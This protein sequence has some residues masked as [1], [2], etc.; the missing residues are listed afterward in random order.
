MENNLLIPFYKIARKNPDIVASADAYGESTY[1]QL[2]ENALRF[3]HSISS[4]YLEFKKVAIFLPNGTEALSAII[5]TLTAGIC[6]TALD[7]TT[8]A[9]RNRVIFEFGDF[10]FLLTN[11]ELFFDAEKFVSKEKILI[12]QDTLQSEPI[13]V[14]SVKDVNPGDGAIMYFTSGSTG[15]PKGVIHSHKK[16]ELSLKMG[17]SNEMSHYCMIVPLG[18]VASINLFFPLFAGGKVSFFDIK[19]N[20]IA[21]YTRF[22]IEEKITHAMLVVTAFRAVA[23]VL[24]EGEKLASLKHLMLAGEPVQSSDLELFRSLTTPSAILSQYYG[25]SETRTISFIQIGHQ[26]KFPDKLSAGKPLNGISI[27]ILDESLQILSKGESGQIAVSS[28]IMATEY[29]KDE[30]S[31]R[32]SFLVHPETGEL[33]Y[34]TGD[35][36]YLSEDGNLFHQ[37]RKDFMVKVRGSRVDILEIEECILSHQGINDGIVVN[38]GD[39]FSETLLVA[40]IKIKGETTI[41]NL[42][43]YVSSRLPSY[44]IPSFFIIKEDLPQTSTGK[45]DR[46]KLTEEPLDYSILLK[47]GEESQIEFDPLYQRLKSI[48]M[49]ELKLPRLSPHHNFFNDLGG[50]SILAVSVLERIKK[51]LAIHLPYFILYR[52]RT[53]GKLTD[54][55]HRRGNKL[56]SIEMLQAPKDKQSPAIIFVPPIKGGADTYNFSQKTFP[57]HYGLFALTYNIIDDDNQTFYRLDQIMNSCVELIKDSD[58]QNL[59]LF[60]YS[61]GGL[62]AFEIAQRLQQE[63]VKKLILIDI[64]PARKKNVNLLMFIANDI[65]LSWK[66][67]LKGYFKPIRVNYQHIIFCIPY[68]FNKGQMIRKKEAKNH[69]TMAEAAHIRFYKQFNHGKFDGDL[70]LILSTDNRFIKSLFN[71][72]KFVAGSI[73]TKSVESGHHDLLQG[74]KS[75]IITQL[76]IESIERQ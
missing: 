37:G 40:Y 65:R 44:M 28:P 52:Y 53:L 47:G 46:K 15:V 25:T 10:D 3:Y 6:H 68:F 51:E 8:P 16:L 4:H 70:L 22:L 41:A 18:F 11:Q 75:K 56:V 60:G 66:A 36:G 71:W 43:S 55:I 74:N 38:K 61:M 12:Y 34:L 27:Y 9:E 50:D 7:T 23:Q 13:D 72:E 67:M 63:Y 31:T 62:L 76:V 64:P 57:S 58:F 5:S 21:A 29:Y 49:E 2:Y 42:R 24:K 32:R 54:Y 73:E 1:G 20:G 17:K 26:D 30:E 33:I 59:Y 69:L 45:T 19:K 39:S 14:G 48:W 35:V